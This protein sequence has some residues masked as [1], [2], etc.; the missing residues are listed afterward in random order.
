MGMYQDYITRSGLNIAACVAEQLVGLSIHK[1]SHLS[2]LFWQ[3]NTHFNHHVLLLGWI[4]PFFL[5]GQQ[6]EET[7]F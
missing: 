6:T 2:F 3:Q 1:T 7:Y 4:L 5:L